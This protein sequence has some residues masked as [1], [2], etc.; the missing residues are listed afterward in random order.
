MVAV[1]AACPSCGQDFTGKFCAHCGEKQVNHH[2][3]TAGHFVEETVEG[4]THFDNKFI[5]T[6]KA[7]FRPGMLTLEF[8]RGRK[9]PFMRPIQLF[10]VCNLLFFLLAGRTNV[11]SVQLDNFMTRPSMRAYLIARVGADADFNRVGEIFVEKMGNQSKA[12]ILFFVP[13]YA[14][15]TELVYFRKRKPAGMHLVFATHY[16][17]FLLFYFALF[18]L[19]LELPYYHIFRGSVAFFDPF[20]VIFNLLAIIIYFLLAARRY[21]RAGW[22]WAILGGV[23]AGFLFIFLLVIYRSLLFYNIVRTIH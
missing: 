10:I 11:F 7:L 17:S 13:F 18:E 14:L 6:I 4:I 23:G 2:D 12:F 5:R 15:Y 22:T 9:V 1:S 21:F 3:F 8:E 16:F 20:A 19:L